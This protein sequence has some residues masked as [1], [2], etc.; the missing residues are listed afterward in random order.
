MIRGVNPDGYFPVTWP[1]VLLKRSFPSSLCMGMCARKLGMWACVFI[2]CVSCVIIS[3]WPSVSFI[4]TLCSDPSATLL[5]QHPL[6]LMTCR[7]NCV[8]VNSQLG[9]SFS[10]LCVHSLSFCTTCISQ[11]SF[12]LKNHSVPA[13]STIRHH[14]DSLFIEVAT[15]AIDTLSDQ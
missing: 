4:H 1:I 9:L 5:I 13:D 15:Q 6:S 12:P 2:S 3:V 7:C 11:M 8:C 14:L 10:P